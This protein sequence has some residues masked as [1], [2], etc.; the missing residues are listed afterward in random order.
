MNAVVE[1]AANA[2]AD[3]DEQPCGKSA[4]TADHTNN[5]LLHVLITFRALA[6]AFWQA[7]FRGAVTGRH[8]HPRS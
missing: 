4:N 5:K 2:N 7:P 3:A 6:L 1:Y 8:P